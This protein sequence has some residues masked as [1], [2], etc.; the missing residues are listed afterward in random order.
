VGRHSAEEYDSKDEVT[1]VLSHRRSSDD[2]WYI[3]ALLAV[4][5]FAGSVMLVWDPLGLTRLVVSLLS[6]V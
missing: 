5:F 4:I 2:G 3:V 1:V 6:R